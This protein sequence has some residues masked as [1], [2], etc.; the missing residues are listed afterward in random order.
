MISSCLLLHYYY[1]R[2]TKLSIRF[3][4][5]QKFAFAIALKYYILESIIN[6]ITIDN[7]IATCPR[8]RSSDTDALSRPSA[9]HPDA[10]GRG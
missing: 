10:Q 1:V 7:E 3:L 2:V 4:Q 5:K 9:S 6:T 8:P